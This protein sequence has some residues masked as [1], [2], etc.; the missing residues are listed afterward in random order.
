MKRYAIAAF[1]AA[2]AIGGSA[3]A[4]DVAPGE[5]SVDWSGLSVGASGMLS[6]A[7]SN[8][9]EVEIRPNAANIEDFALNLHRH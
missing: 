3:L 7:G 5:P 8:H 6:N 2:F 9:A 4:A 1:F